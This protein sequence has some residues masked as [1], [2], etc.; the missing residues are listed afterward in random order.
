MLFHQ[1]AGVWSVKL[2]DYE[3]YEIGDNFASAYGGPTDYSS[4]PAQDCE[5]I[6]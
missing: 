4:A 2:K 1:E 5:H 3:G 6:S